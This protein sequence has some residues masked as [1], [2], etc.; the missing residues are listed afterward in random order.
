MSSI[1]TLSN[2][3]NKFMNYLQEYGLYALIG[4]IF[5]GVIILIF[6]LII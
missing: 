3:F 4:S 2:D 5:L 1:F 6:A